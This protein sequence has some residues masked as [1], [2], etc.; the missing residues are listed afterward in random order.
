MKKLIQ[1][2]GVFS[3]LCLSFFLY[4]PTTFAH[5]GGL[6]SNGGHKCWTNCYKYDLKFGEYHMHQKKKST[7][8]VV[9]N[10][11]S[12][13]D[14]VLKENT[15][16]LAAE[17]DTNTNEKK[18]DTTVWGT[19]LAFFAAIVAYVKKKSHQFSTWGSQYS[20]T[21][22]YISTILGL[23]FILFGIF[24]IIQS[25]WLWALFLIFIGLFLFDPTERLIE[26][27]IG[28]QINPALQIVLNITGVIITIIA[29]SIIF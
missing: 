1:S 19:I 24:L 25:L 29:S 15:G 27:C 10:T 9:D 22:S 21:I 3:F 16:T 28:K 18:E 14:D 11:R 12:D 2:I 7:T 23:V 13:I 26:K 8:N 5:P 6:D 20:K 4:N 17:S